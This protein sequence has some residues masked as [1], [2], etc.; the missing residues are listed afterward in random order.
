MFNMPVRL[1]LCAALVLSTGV[2]AKNRELVVY[3]LDQ[4]PDQDIADTK[5]LERHFVEESSF[6][7][8]GIPR[9]RDLDKCRLENNLAWQMILPTDQHVTER[10]RYGFQGV[11]QESSAA[12]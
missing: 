8:Q 1:A 7:T 9:P 10:I 11:R 4:W 2:S 5:A 6:A 3:P 12:R